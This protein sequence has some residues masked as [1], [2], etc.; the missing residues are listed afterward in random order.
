[1]PCTSRSNPGKRLLNSSRAK[2]KRIVGLLASPRLEFS[3]N[4]ICRWPSRPER[5]YETFPSYTQN[6]WPARWFLTEVAVEGHGPCRDRTRHTA[7]LE[8]GI[9]LTIQDEVG[10]PVRAFGVAATDCRICRAVSCQRLLPGSVHQHDEFARSGAVHSHCALCIFSH[11]P[12]AV[13]ATR[14][15]PVPVRDVAELAFAEPQLRSRLLIP[16]AF[17]RPPPVL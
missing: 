3:R 2:R 15:A 14:S 12:A 11:S 17:I 10:A 13:T 4:E 16:S 5:T 7:G 8:S 9:V 1:M 6:Y